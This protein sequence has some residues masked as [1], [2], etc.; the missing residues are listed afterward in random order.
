MARTTLNDSKLDDKFW[1]QGIDTVVFIINK[2]F[3]RNN[4]NMNPY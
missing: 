4:C 3:P 2:G 1:I